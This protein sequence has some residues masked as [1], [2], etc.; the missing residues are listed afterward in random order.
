MVKSGKRDGSLITGE[1][2][3]ST[4]TSVCVCL[5]VFTL[6]ACIHKLALPCIS[7]VSS[8]GAFGI[9]FIGGK[10]VHSFGLPFKL[11]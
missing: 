1:L 2:V 11:E 5:C 10:K 3:L 9:S 4:Q 6:H 7:G 8:S